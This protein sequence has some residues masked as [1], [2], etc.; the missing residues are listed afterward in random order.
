MV[1]STRIASLDHCA[2]GRAIDLS[3]NLYS[4]PHFSFLGTIVL[5]LCRLATHLPLAVVGMTSSYSFVG[6][7]GEE[8]QN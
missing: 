4:A 5:R 8:K 7:R 2:D 6:R 3:A 1:T